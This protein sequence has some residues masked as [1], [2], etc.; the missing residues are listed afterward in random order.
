MQSFAMFLAQ[1]KEHK[2][3]I[4]IRLPFTSR[5]T[6]KLNNNSFSIPGTGSNSAQELNVNKFYKTFEELS[7]LDEF[8]GTT[9]QHLV[10]I[11]GD[12]STGH[13]KRNG[14]QIRT[15]LAKH[16]I[17]EKYSVYL[18]ESGG[19]EVLKESTN[20][21][22]TNKLNT[23]N[24][25]H[26]AT[27][28]TTTGNSVLVNG[29]ALNG[30]LNGSTNGQTL[31]NGALANGHEPDCSDENEQPKK[32]NGTASQTTKKPRLQSEHDDKVSVI[33]K[34]NIYVDCDS[35]CALFFTSVRRLECCSKRL[36]C[37]IRSN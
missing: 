32:C 30:T 20:K 12:Q 1:K 14:I 15:H 34:L 36:T 2:N 35:P 25:I 5:F 28:G 6:L 13:F 7:D 24:G 16:F 21:L 37:Q 9:I 23:T 4:S 11:D 17:S 27:N 31:T 10:Y 22:N 19:K 8:K 3:S 26:P 29:A 33:D 18:P